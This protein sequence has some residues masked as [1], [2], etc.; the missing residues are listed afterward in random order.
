M[1]GE[2]SGEASSLVVVLHCIV[3]TFIKST[4][5]WLSP[6]PAAH[7]CRP[8]GARSIYQANHE[9]ATRR[10]AQA[11]MHLYMRHCHLFGYTADSIRRPLHQQHMEQRHLPGYTADSIRHPLH[12]QHLGQQYTPKASIP[13]MAFRATFVSP[14]IYTAN[15]ILACP[16]TSAS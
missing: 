15:V 4:H 2:P 1:Q 10:G 8:P 3:H 16:A 9:G 6:P 11:R 12:Q 7:P 5:P 13:P 14:V